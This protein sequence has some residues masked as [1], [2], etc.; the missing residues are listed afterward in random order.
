MTE[1]RV[2]MTS[3]QQYALI[4]LCCGLAFCTLILIANR[5]DRHRESSFVRDGMNALNSWRKD[6]FYRLFDDFFIPVLVYCSVMLFWPVAL[7]FKVKAKFFKT[8]TPIKRTPLVEV[9]EFVLS[10]TELIR[11]VSVQEVER[12]NFIS[13]PM[14]AVPNL[15]FGHCNA[16]WV[17]LRDSIKAN[18]TLWEFES[19]RSELEGS[20][21]M[22]GY[23]VKAE[24]GSIERF[25]TT[26]WK[27]ELPQQSHSL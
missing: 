6:F 9:K 4:Y 18:E 3:W 7:W 10:P 13:D 14:E 11:E 12:T 5:I 17:T 15:P 8:A 23:A 2:A 27:I 21:M 22:W 19:S 1:S 20:E 25:M 26:G 16:Q 24:D